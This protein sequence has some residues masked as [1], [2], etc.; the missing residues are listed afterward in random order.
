MSVIEKKFSSLLVT[1]NKNN[2][3][4]INDEVDN[5]LLS[6]KF[7]ACTVTGLWNQ[8]IFID[9]DY[10]YSDNFLFIKFLNFKK[11]LDFTVAILEDRINIS[12]YFNKN[13]ITVTFIITKDGETDKI[14]LDSFRITYDKV[15]NYIAS[16]I[17]LI[18]KIDGYEMETGL[19]FM[20]DSH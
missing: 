6:E 2:R 3:M 4:V 15:L 14:T 1:H 16:K 7:K 5:F 17:N 8:G 11:G 18:N 12:F 13:Q 9:D 10:P 19:A 20:G